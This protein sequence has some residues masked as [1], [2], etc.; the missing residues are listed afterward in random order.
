MKIISVKPAKS[1]VKRVVCKDCGA[2]IEYTPND[3]ITLWSSRDYGGGPDG[4]TGF[5]CP[6]C[7]K[8]II[9]T[10]W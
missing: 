6:N 1:V 10:R 2:K 9:I 7:S 8:N 4:A 5:K 3:V